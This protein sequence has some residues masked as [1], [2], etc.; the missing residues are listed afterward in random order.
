MM[1]EALNLMGIGM[2]VVF[3]VLALFFFIIRLLM[4]MFPKDKDQDS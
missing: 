2:G 1:T 3:A 4:K